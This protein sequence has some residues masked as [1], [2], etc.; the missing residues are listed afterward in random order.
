M[1]CNIN[2]PVL[3][4]V[5]STKLALMLSELLYSTRSHIILL[6]VELVIIFYLAFHV[7]CSSILSQRHV[8]I[9]M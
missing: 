7:V 8:M 3:V 5:L 1:E 2:S 4:D 9:I 6:T